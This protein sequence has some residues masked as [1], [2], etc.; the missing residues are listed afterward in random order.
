[1]IHDKLPTATLANPVHLFALGWGAGL[2][3]Y[4][5]GTCATL[6]AIPLYL[7]VADLPLWIYLLNTVLLFAVGVWLCHVT[8]RDL[9]KHDH[10]AIVWDEIVGYLITMTAAPRGWLWIALGF[11]LFRLFDIWKPWPIRRIDRSV[12]GGLGIMLDDGLAGIYAFIVLQAI[13]HVL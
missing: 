7:L 5:P 2:S 3:P 11:G 1:M 6:L 8:A 12:D 9:N 10:P 13:A 4:A